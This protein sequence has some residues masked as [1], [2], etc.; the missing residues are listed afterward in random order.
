ME[1]TGRL[2]TWTGRYSFTRGDVSVV[3][4][5]ALVS[6]DGAIPTGSIITGGYLDVVVSPSTLDAS[7]AGPSTIALKVE[8]ANDVINAAA[9]TGA[10][11]STTGRKDIIPDSTGS[12]ALKT[13][14]AREPSMVIAVE[15][16]DAG[17]FTLVLFYK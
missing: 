16:L 9:V 4:T 12:T 15:D 17:D 1:G 10:P 5:A 11:W 7:S 6:D 2:K 14:A 8:G 13:T 3:G